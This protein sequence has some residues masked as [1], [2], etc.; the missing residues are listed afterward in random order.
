MW[1]RAL[2]FLLRLVQFTRLL[3]W[4][5]RSTHHSPLS[6]SSE[7]P[8]SF[9]WVMPTG[10][11]HKKFCCIITVYLGSRHLVPLSYNSVKLGP[12]QP[13]WLSHIIV[14]RIFWSHIYEGAKHSV[15]AGKHLQGVWGRFRKGGLLAPAQSSLLS[16]L[17]LQSTPDLALATVPSSLW[18]PVL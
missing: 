16:P 18:T 5:K 17:T 10:M 1:W 9:G 11:N 6:A 7:D 15:P 2:S 13:S 12:R 3:S 14:V 4:D 8:P